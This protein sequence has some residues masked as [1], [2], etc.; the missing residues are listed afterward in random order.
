LQDLIFYNRLVSSA[1]M[2]FREME[3]KCLVFLA[4]NLSPLKT[5]AK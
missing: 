1:G 5:W 3:L 4:I 2:N